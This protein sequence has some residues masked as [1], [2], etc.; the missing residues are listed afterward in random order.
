MTRLPTC[1]ACATAL[2]SLAMALASASGAFAHVTLEHGE[3][4][5]NS[6]HKSVFRVP[7]GCE[8]SATIAVR[9]Q[10]PDGVRDQLRAH[11]L[12]DLSNGGR[13]I[14][15]QLEAWFIN[16]LARALFEAN[17]PDGAART[18]TALAERDGIPTITLG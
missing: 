9:I 13:G 17:L 7:H 1:A 11:C 3:A 14:G 16:P 4:P 2:L 8:G 12:K 18:A 5:A 6:F 10:I 15:N